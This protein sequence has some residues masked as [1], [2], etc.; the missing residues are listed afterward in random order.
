MRTGYAIKDKSEHSWLKSREYVPGVQCPVSVWVQEED[1]A[2]TFRDLK[3]AK[4]LLKLVRQSQRHPER[5][6]VLNPNG[7]VVAN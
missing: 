2:L 1:E 4:R 5:I 7:K 6:V 3:L